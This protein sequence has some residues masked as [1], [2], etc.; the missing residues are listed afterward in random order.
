M[1]AFLL[2]GLAMTAMQPVE[3]HWQSDLAFPGLPLTESWGNV[4]VQQ[5][6]LKGKLDATGNGSG[7]IILDFNTPTYDEVG[8]VQSITVMPL[9]DAECTLKLVKQ[10]QRPSETDAKATNDWLVIAIECRKLKSRFFVSYQKNDPSQARLL[11]EGQPGEIKYVV[12]MKSAATLSKP[13]QRAV[14][15]ALTYSVGR[16][17]ARDE[18]QQTITVETYSRQAYFARAERELVNKP[19]PH[20]VW[21]PLME[22]GSSPIQEVLS[23][24]RIALVD[25]QGRDIAREER[26]KRLQIGTMLIRQDRVEKINPLIYQLM[27]KETV[28][29]FP[30]GIVT[31]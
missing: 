22:I 8:N 12:Q 18:Q 16:V 13:D 26:W 29:L 25:S 19:E 28:L 10:L 23:V 4:S 24:N 1:L 27:G 2:T 31:R 21:R 11:I 7:Q 6:Q 14:S 15:A 9:F 20:Y 3:R 17:I 30:S 5:F